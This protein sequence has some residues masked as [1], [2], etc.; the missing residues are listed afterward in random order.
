MSVVPL[1]KELRVVKKAMGI[2]TYM[3]SYNL[4]THILIRMYSKICIH[5][6]TLY[7]EE[8]AEGGKEGIHIWINI[9]ISGHIFPFTIPKTSKYYVYG[10]TI[11]YL[12]EGAEG[13]EEGH[14]GELG[15][16]AEIPQH[17]LELSCHTIEGHRQ[18]DQ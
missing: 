16:L 14:G 10:C 17:V 8:G 3:Q 2:H 18:E 6:S 1:R 7:L 9:E 13:G 12:E 5:R 11:L 4:W 15:V